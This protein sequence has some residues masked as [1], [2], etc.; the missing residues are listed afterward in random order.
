MDRKAR[1][2]QFGELIVKRREV[3]LTELAERESQANSPVD[4]VITDVKQTELN[5]RLIEF[6][7]NELSQVDVSLARIK[8]GVYGQ[9]DEC[10]SKI[11]LARLNALPYAVTCIE[12]Q[13][14]IELRELT[15]LD[16][17]EVPGDWSDILDGFALAGSSTAPSPVAGADLYSGPSTALERPAE[18]EQGHAA[19][20]IPLVLTRRKNE[21]IVIGDDI[22]V[23]V[24]EIRG[25]MVRLGIQI[26]KESTV[27]LG[28]TLRA[29]APGTSAL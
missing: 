28:E 20:A 3:L 10:G 5:S 7:R 12:C 13:R 27:Q 21:S 14:K 2:L 18:Q 23:V 29:N 15:P 24:I 25:D 9:C 6:H 19:L 22:T 16:S 17:G 11:P 4:L 8:R 1:L 26:P